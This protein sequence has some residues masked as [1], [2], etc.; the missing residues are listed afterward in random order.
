MAQ[1][2]IDNK[3]VHQLTID[4]DIRETDKAVCRV[5]LTNVLKGQE[6]LILNIKYQNFWVC[7][8]CSLDLADKIKNMFD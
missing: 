2:K 1:I 4:K 5:C 8:P 3:W 6:S 7:K